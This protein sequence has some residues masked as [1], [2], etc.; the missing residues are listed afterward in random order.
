MLC[1]QGKGSLDFFL[2]K[3]AKAFS[4]IEVAGLANLKATGERLDSA[5]RFTGALYLEGLLLVASSHEDEQIAVQIAEEQ[6][7]KLANEEVD[8]SLV[9]PTLIKKAETLVK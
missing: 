8:R 6:I 5:L 7:R 1:L 9:H 4:L 2:K 3:Y